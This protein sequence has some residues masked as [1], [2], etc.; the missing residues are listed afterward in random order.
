VLPNLLHD[1]L[2]FEASGFAAFAHRFATRDALAGQALR[3]S[4]GTEGI[5]QGVDGTGALQV[6]TA[7]GLR[8][9]NSAEVSVRPA[10]STAGVVPC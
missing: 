2:A 4:D 3:L 7:Q 9:V 6:L 1:V 8:S 5:G 10:A